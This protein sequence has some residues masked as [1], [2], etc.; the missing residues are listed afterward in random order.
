M[1]V[2][3]LSEPLFALSTVLLT[4]VLSAVLWYWRGS[5][6]EQEEMC[7][8]ATA[9]FGSPL[10]FELRVLRAFR[11][12]I[13]LRGRPGRALVSTYYT[14]SPPIARFIKRKEGLRAFVRSL[15]RLA[16]RA[17]STF[18]GIR[19]ETLLRASPKGRR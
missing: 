17:C 9:A 12:R 4:I 15:T 8:I 10:V 14:F 6:V 2:G 7:F 18:T 16:I 5:R 19:T 11:D 13:L 1:D 3:F